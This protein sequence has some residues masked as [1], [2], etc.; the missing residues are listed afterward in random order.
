MK[1]IPFVAPGSIS[2]PCRSI[3]APQSEASNGIRVCTSTP[4]GPTAS[5]AAR[6]KSTRSVPSFDVGSDV[7]ENP[8]S[9]KPTVQMPNELPKSTVTVVPYCGS[10]SAVRFGT[11]SVPG[12]PAP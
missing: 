1:L 3:S 10:T 6:R 4:V 2:I 9:R 11:P 8:T 7:S 12:Q 5:G